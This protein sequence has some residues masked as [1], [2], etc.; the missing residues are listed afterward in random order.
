MQAD[1]NINGNKL[2]NSTFIQGAAGSD[3]NI[4]PGS[5]FNIV[6]PT[7]MI[8]CGIPLQYGLFASGPNG[9]NAIT[10]NYDDTAGESVTINSADIQAIF[11]DP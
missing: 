2:I 7:G 11:I 10:F 6:T 8:N 1:L 5:G 9:V 3:I 4:L